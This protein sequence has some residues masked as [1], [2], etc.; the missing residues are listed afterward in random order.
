V[1]HK[2]STTSLF[3]EADCDGRADHEVL[4]QQRGVDWVNSAV[5]LVAG[6]AGADGALQQSG[7]RYDR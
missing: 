4:N 6:G 1:K 5:A 3:N 2:R 7:E